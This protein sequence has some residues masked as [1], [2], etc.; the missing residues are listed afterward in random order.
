M[1]TQLHQITNWPELAEAA[2][3]RANK[4]AKACKVSVRTLERFFIK[5]FEK[6]PKTWMAEQRQIQ[7]AKRLKE[8]LWS[9]EVAMATD[10]KTQSQFSREFKAY[11]GNCPSEHVKTQLTR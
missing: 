7:A 1:H 3:W 11:W 2:S 9:K 4:V 6:T 10:Y 8:G 5:K